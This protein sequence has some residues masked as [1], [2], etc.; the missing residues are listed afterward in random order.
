MCVCVSSKSACK[1]QVI[2]MT[3]AR[4]LKLRWQ[5]MVLRR[6]QLSDLLS[7]AQKTGWP[8]DVQRLAQHELMSEIGDPVPTSQNVP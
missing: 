1:N 5:P 2:H 6:P 7:H 4:T 3:W 8:R